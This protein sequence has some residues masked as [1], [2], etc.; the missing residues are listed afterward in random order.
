MGKATSKLS[1]EDASY[2][3]G[4]THFN[5]KELQQ[6]YKGFMSECPTGGISR[7]QFNDLFKQFFPFGDSNAYADH[8]FN[9][10]DADKNGVVDFREFMRAISIT[11]KGSLDEK[12]AWAFKLYDLDGDGFI[13]H[14]ELLRVVTAIYKC[15]GSTAKHATDEDT[16]EKRV[17]K[18]LGRLDKTDCGRVSLNDFVA[19]SQTDATAV[20]A[21]AMFNTLV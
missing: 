16:P 7:T 17:E 12:T 21:L 1:N 19:G 10:F 20:Q 8:A 9:M 3:E 2:L 18:L 5:R 14:E 11:S 13:T 15:V 6:W 4:S